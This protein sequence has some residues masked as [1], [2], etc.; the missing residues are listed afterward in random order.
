MAFTC[1][2]CN[3][4]FTRKSSL[5]AHK[6]TTKYCLS[7]RGVSQPTADYACVSCGKKYSIKK[8]FEKHMLKCLQHCDQVS[9]TKADYDAIKIATECKKQI[10]AELEPKLVGLSNNVTNNI[11]KNITNHNNINIIYISPINLDSDYIKN[12]VL[13]NFTKEH[14][15]DGQRG[16]AMFTHKNLL[17]DDYSG[18]VKYV[19]GDVS[20]NVYYFFDGT[21]IQKDMKATLV[22]ESIYNDIVEK[23]KEIAVRCTEEIPSQM[24]H[25]GKQLKELVDMKKNST[26][27]LNCLTTVV[28]KKAKNSKILPKEDTDEEEEEEDE[29]EDDDVEEDDD[30][31]FVIVPGEV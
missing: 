6:K 24:C 26:K 18:E 23:S 7:I 30:S 10:M 8:C 4:N 3:T 25:Y 14:F 19:C 21:N 9:S 29:E 31:I 16:A 12:K 2:F 28:K 20:R 22:R 27:F 5:L 17:E 15:L 13:T 1:E 11:T